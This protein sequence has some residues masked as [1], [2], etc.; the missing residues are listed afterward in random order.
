MAG[1]ERFTPYK[2]EDRSPTIPIHKKK[3][4]KGKTVLDKKRALSTVKKL[5]PCF[6]TRQ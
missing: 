4:E 3:K 1:R 6:L 5:I 2:P